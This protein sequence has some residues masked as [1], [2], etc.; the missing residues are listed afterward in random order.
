M[1][2]EPTVAPS[3]DPSPLQEVKILDLYWDNNIANNIRS[4]AAGRNKNIV[5]LKGTLL[6]AGLAA[7]S[8]EGT[9]DFY[10]TE[11]P[12]SQSF[13]LQKTLPDEAP[14]DG[15]GTGTGT[16]TGVVW[17]GRY[18]GSFEMGVGHVSETVHLTF[19]A[20]DKDDT[21]T[22]TYTIQGEGHNIY[23][24]FVLEG[25]A[26]DAVLVGG[27]VCNTVTVQL[28]KTYLG[29]ESKMNPKRKRSEISSQSSVLSKM[30]RTKDEKERN[31]LLSG[32]LFLPDTMLAIQ[33]NSDNHHATKLPATRVWTDVSWDTIT[34]KDDSGPPINSSSS[35][36][37]SSSKGMTHDPNLICN[38]CHV[39]FHISRHKMNNDTNV[40]SSSSGMNRS[41][42]E[43]STRGLGYDGTVLDMK[44]CESCR[45]SPTEPTENNA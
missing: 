36:S 39:P 35:S 17:S 33:Y 7:I 3:V 30:D 42:L 16:G 4:R 11:V 45:R 41:G 34:P 6:K 5:Q 2:D 24:K 31:T 13:S 26:T 21:Q 20:T 29:V 12:T 9:W 10:G 27:D 37:S 8:L 43:L 25:S 14:T 38:R 44:P 28:I 40:M 23:G 15:T 1:M 32:F 19:R 18:E 22:H